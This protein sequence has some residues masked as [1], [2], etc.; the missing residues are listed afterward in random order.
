MTD[1]MRRIRAMTE[2]LGLKR[3]RPILVA[4]RLPDSTGFSLESGLD[5]ETWLKEGLMDVLITTD[6]FRLNPWS[7][8]VELG[9]RHGVK[10]YPA[11]T[12][13][14]VI[15]ETRF[16]RASVPAYRARAANAWASGA[17]GLYCFNLYDIDRQSPLWRELGDPQSL[18]YTEKL[19]F[20]TDLDGRPTSWLAKGDRHQTIPLVTPT[21]P[22]N[23]TTNQGFTSQMMIADDLAAATRAGFEA[24]PK[25][26]L[27]LP[28]LDDAT[29]IRVAFNGRALP[30]GKLYNGWIDW[31]LAPA[32]LKKGKND[33]T[34]SLQRAAPSPSSEWTLSY[35][36]NARP[37]KPWR[38]D[39]GS[40]RIHEAIEDGALLLADRGTDGG[41]FCYYRAA[42]GAD[43]EGESVVEAHLKVISGSS[44]LIFGTGVSGERIEFSPG[45]V[46]L[47]HQRQHRH[48]MS[49]TDD[50]HRYRL[51]IKGALL[52][53]YVDGIQRINAPAALPARPEYTRNEIAF[54]AANSPNLGEALWREI[55]VRSAQQSQPLQDLVLSVS[56][57]KQAA[58]GR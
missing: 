5:L 41:D 18:A 55:R 29:R 43:P 48:A 22:V 56:Y 8:S 9:H 33:I 40:P 27:D 17:N 21:Y 53:L 12:D 25:L 34:V 38:R 6:Y 39:K 31:A 7:Y 50:F 58:A 23:L 51:V 44:F 46:G 35:E 47:Y 57:R 14:R 24:T 15:G 45:G 4:M 28:G 52:Q 26:H 36:G 13:P 49:T 30:E 19:Y 1:L 37:G 2:D 10:V 54:G 42:W 3:Q 20:L 32:Q 16:M 11:L